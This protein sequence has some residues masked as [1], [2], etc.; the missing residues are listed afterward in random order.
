MAFCTNCDN[1]GSIDCPYCSSSG[2][3]NDGEGGI[4]RCEA[5]GKDGQPPG[6][7]CCPECNGNQDDD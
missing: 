3:F 7:M 5:C 6:Q 1:T 4:I 2:D